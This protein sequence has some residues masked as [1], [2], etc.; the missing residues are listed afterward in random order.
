LAI[1]L[2]AKDT[3]KDALM[4]VLPVP[5]VDASRHLARAA[6]AAMLAV[7]ADSPIGAVIACNFHRSTAVEGL[8]QLPG[9]IVE[10][11][12]RCDRDLAWAR[13][14]ARAGNRHTGHFDA[15][16]TS[17]ELWHDDV[18]QPIAG[19][20]PVVEVDTNQ[21]VDAEMSSRTS[22]HSCANDATYRRL[23]ATLL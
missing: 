14:Q 9:P 11:F 2:V 18:T 4:A 15:V 6:I 23:S 1:P 8:S 22:V 21:A 7:A 3:I 16:R 10:V 20:W 12:C 17:D 13:Y 5:D 19:G